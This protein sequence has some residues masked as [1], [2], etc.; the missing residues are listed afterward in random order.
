MKFGR[1]MLEEAYEPFQDNYISYKA[2]KK[3]IKLITGNDTSTC[4][5]SEVTDSFSELLTLKNFAHQSVIH[6]LFLLTYHIE[7][8]FIF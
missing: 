6:I 3:A 2:L 1:R 7:I 5:I 8:F 4:T